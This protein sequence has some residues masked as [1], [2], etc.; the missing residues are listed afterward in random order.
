MGWGSVVLGEVKVHDVPGEHRDIV[1]LPWASDLGAE[2]RKCLDLIDSQAP[3]PS[4]VRPLQVH[5]PPCGK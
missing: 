1:R 4:N 2:I 5:T 3:G